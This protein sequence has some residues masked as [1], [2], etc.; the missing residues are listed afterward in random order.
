MQEWVI[1]LMAELAA[2][3]SLFFYWGYKFGLRRGAALFHPT[4]FDPNSI[5]GVCGRLER[6]HISCPAPV[7]QKR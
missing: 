7:A 2:L 3:G 6:E 1:I 5:C 4:P